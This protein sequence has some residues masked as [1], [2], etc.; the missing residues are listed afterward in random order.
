MKRHGL[1]L[2]I[3]V[4]LL[5]ISTAEAA[6]LSLELVF[7]SPQTEMTRITLVYEGIIPVYFDE[8]PI[9][10]ALG[11]LGPVALEP[12]FYE[13]YLS[14]ASREEVR[15]FRFALAADGTV[16]FDPAEG[17]EQDGNRIVISDTP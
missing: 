7:P 8:V 5:F 12:A 10:V 17:L 1:I 3:L 16:I 2:A 9:G 6:D 11:T 15:R 13:L 4:I 14:V